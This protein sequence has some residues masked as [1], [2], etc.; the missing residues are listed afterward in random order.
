M[1][2][3]I[4]NILLNAGGIGALSLFTIWLWKRESEKHDRFVQQIMNDSKE[5][6]RDSRA[7]LDAQMQEI[8]EEREEMKQDRLEYQMTINKFADHLGTLTAKVERLDDLNN[9]VKDIGRKVDTL[10]D[11]RKDDR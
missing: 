8:R 1:E 11:R 2:Q 9:E 10:M 7:Y 5:R 4:T 3:A 6:E